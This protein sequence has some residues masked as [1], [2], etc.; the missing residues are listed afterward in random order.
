LRKPTFPTSLRGTGCPKRKRKIVRL[1]RVIME[2]E[3]ELSLVKDAV[4]GILERSKLLF[5]CSAL[6]WY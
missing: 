6:F 1:F 2:K 5:N 3:V 4:D